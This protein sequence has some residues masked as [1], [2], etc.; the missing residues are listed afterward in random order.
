[1]SKLTDIGKDSFQADIEQLVSPHTDRFINIEVHQIFYASSCPLNSVPM[2]KVDVLPI[3]YD[4]HLE[5]SSSRHKV[6]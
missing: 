3:H 5:V 6:M 4:S 2:R 1:M